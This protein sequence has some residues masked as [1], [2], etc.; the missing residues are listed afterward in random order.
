MVALLIDGLSGEPRGIHRTFLRP[1][2][3]GKAEG[4]AKLMLG[5]SG[6]VRLVDD[7]DVGVALGIAE[8][9]ETSLAVMQLAGWRPVWSCGSAG[10]IAGFPVLPGIETLTIFADPGEAGEEAAVKCAARWAEAGREV[11]ILLPPELAGKPDADWLDV[12]VARVRAK[13][14]E[15]V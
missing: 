13:K 14:S 15:P 1:D 4:R 7:Q 6:I 3:A 9:I 5:G 12:L 11:E 8:G 10:G 2:G